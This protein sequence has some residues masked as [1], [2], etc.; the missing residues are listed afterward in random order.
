MIRLEIAPDGTQTLTE[1]CDKCK[2]H[3]NNLTVDDIL[4]KKP[5][6]LIIKN[7][8]G[9]EITNTAPRGE[10]KCPDCTHD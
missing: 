4:V 2:C 1:I 10:C 8:K 9:E 3:V 6:D 5:S 7:S